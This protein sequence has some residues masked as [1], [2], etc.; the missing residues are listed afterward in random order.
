MIASD[1]PQLR[2]ATNLSLYLQ[3][4]GAGEGVEAGWGS[5]GTEGAGRPHLEDSEPGSRLP[6]LEGQPKAA[7]QDAEPCLLLS[8][9]SLRSEAQVLQTC[10]DLLRVTAAAPRSV[11]R[12]HGLCHGKSSGTPGTG[13]G[14]AGGLDV[15]WASPL[16]RAEAGA[17][18]SLSLWATEPSC[19]ALRGTCWAMETPPIT[20][21][22]LGTGSG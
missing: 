11:P 12:H 16:Y 15:C 10:F 13:P 3:A 19:L 5:P 9:L 4:A 14:E 22:C 7:T 21:L 6:A 18:S 8:A 2:T 17:A 1:G 20:Q